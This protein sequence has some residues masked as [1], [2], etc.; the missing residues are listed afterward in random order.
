MKLE[1][2][3]MT[4]SLCATTCRDSKFNYAGIQE[5]RYCYCGQSDYDKYGPSTCTTKCT[6]DASQICGDPDKITVIPS[7][8]PGYYGNLCEE[9][10]VENWCRHCNV[11]TGKCPPTPKPPTISPPI[12]PIPV[13]MTTRKP[14]TPP[15]EGNKFTAIEYL[16]AIFLLSK[17]LNVLAVVVLTSF[18]F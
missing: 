5:G 15:E 3:A 16:V 18:Q 7:C 6:G 4:W 11:E 8:A 1:S 12:T 14:P 13:P 9:V 10:C 17:Y 2:D